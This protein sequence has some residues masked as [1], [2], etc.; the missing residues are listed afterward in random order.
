MRPTTF[1]RH[2]WPLSIHLFRG[3]LHLGPLDLQQ[4]GHDLPTPLYLYDAATLDAAIASYRHGMKAW[5]GKRLIT[6]ASKAGLSVALA[7]FLA[8][9]GLGLDVVSLGELAIGLRGGFAPEMLHIHGNNKPAGLLQRAIDA[10]TGA[11]VIDNLREL[12][13]LEG[14]SLPRSID[15]WLRMNPNLLAQTHAYR[16]TGHYGSKFGL[17]RAQALL[18]AERIAAHPRLRLTGLH[19]HVGSQV[20]ELD[21]MTQALEHLIDLAVTIEARGWAHIQVLSPGGG[22]GVPYHPDD[23][24]APL[25]SQVQRLCAHAAQAWQKRHGG[26][27][28]TLILEPGRSLVARAGLAL[29]RVGNV[30]TGPNDQRIVAVDGGMSDNIRP[31]LYNARYTAALA[32]NPLGASAGP[33]KIVGPLCES[34]D[35]LIRQV[36]LPHVQPGDVLVMPVAGAYHLSMASNYNGT[37][38]PG[39]WL[40]ARGQLVP[41]QRRETIADLMLRDHFLPAGLRT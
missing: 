25:H 11:I 7:Q 31:A 15:L 14:M 24:R 22:L 5:P 3:R 32:S 36:A 35:F 8:R 4:L 40:H 16:Q 18:A 37:L 1:P 28:P 29:Y 10:N 21:A 20:F 38:R 9:R 2:L 6:Y 39:L 19:A 27:F 33:A 34:G 17:A 26:P 13:L 30:R 12:A 41:M 23:P